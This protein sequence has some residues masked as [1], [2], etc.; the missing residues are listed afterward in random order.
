MSSLGMFP[1]R[2]NLSLQRAP[3]SSLG[4]GRKIRAP[5]NST[6]VCRSCSGQSVSGVPGGSTLGFPRPPLSCQDQNLLW[7]DHQDIKM[8]NVIEIEVPVQSNGISQSQKQN[9]FSEIISKHLI[10]SFGVCIKY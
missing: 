7:F 5:K 6:Q 4:A 1:T 2:D 9:R 8:P 3:L 10:A